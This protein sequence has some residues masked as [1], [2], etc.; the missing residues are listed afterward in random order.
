MACKNGWHRPWEKHRPL[1]QPTVCMITQE[2]PERFLG[3]LIYQYKCSCGRTEHVQHS[4]SEKWFGQM[5]VDYHGKVYS[6]LI[7]SSKACIIMTTKAEGGFCNIFY[8]LWPRIF[9][10]ILNNWKWGFWKSVSR[11]T[12]SIKQMSHDLLVWRNILVSLIENTWA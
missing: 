11:T 1:T 12:S 7:S 9:L 5:L 3:I 6:F 4:V 10:K 8:L 2:Y